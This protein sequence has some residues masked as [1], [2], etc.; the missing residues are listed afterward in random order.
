MIIFPTASSFELTEDKLESLAK[1]LG[2]SPEVL[3][4]FQV[5][6]LEA[7]GLST[8]TTTVFNGSRVASALTKRW[9][10]NGLDAADGGSLCSSAE[11]Q[12]NSS[13]HGQAEP[14]AAEGHLS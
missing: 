8:S 9:L 3:Q 12:L 2:V 7:D 13:S 5:P 14:R 10:E 11:S 6:N 4:G 1:A